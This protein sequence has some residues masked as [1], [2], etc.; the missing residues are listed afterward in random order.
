MLLSWLPFCTAATGVGYY[1]LILFLLFIN[2]FFDDDQLK[3]RLVV[4]LIILKQPYPFL[5][6]FFG[7]ALLFLLKTF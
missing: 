3:A 4:Q 5:S 2:S 6:F 1:K 7:L